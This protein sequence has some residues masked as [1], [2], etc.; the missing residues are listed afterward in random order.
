MSPAFGGLRRRRF[1]PQL[2]SLFVRPLPSRSSSHVNWL[3]R[4]TQERILPPRP[5]HR[6]P[7]VFGCSPLCRA[8]ICF[9]VTSRSYF[10]FSTFFLIFRC[11]GS[12]VHQFWERFVELFR[13]SELLLLVVSCL[14]IRTRVMRGDRHE[15]LDAVEKCNS[16]VTE[17]RFVE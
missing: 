16:R 1:L 5:R 7:L 17:C 14:H 9:S 12:V 13:P 2:R 10:D 3:I 6:H 15:L 4:R 11:R 8:R